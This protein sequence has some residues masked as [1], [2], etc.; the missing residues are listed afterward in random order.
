MGLP[1]IKVNTDELQS[2]IYFWLVAGILVLWR[3]DDI[4]H[5]NTNNWSYLMPVTWGYHPSCAVVFFFCWADPFVI[6]FHLTCTHMHAE[7]LLM[8]WLRLLVL[9]SMIEVGVWILSSCKSACQLAFSALFPISIKHL[10]HL[11]GAHSITPHFPLEPY[12]SDRWFVV[13]INHFLSHAKG[14]MT[15]CSFVLFWFFFFGGGRLNGGRIICH[16]DIQQL[17]TIKF[18]SFFFLPWPI[19]LYEEYIVL[20]H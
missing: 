12:V 15:L 18:M 8:P 20:P 10:H 1:L 11:L 17:C 19:L 4:A 16:K 14:H 2:F 13:G 5:L 3:D 6:L 7:P 9:H